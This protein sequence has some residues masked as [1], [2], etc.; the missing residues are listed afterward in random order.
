MVFRCVSPPAE[1]GPCT[2]ADRSKPVHCLGYEQHISAIN[3]RVRFVMSPLPNPPP[4]RRAAFFSPR[5]FYAPL[6]RAFE[7]PERAST[8]FSS[9]PGWL[10]KS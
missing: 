6:A 10:T 7:T 3:A 9:A 2:L 8:F 5:K 1:I 4:Y